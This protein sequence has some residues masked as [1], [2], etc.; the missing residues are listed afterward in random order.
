MSLAVTYRLP[1]YVA[2]VANP[3][4]DPF[5]GYA[6]YKLQ[7]L[8]N[9]PLGIYTVNGVNGFFNGNVHAVSS[10][11]DS[12]TF[13]YRINPGTY[14]AKDP[15]HNY[16]FLD[17][18]NIEFAYRPYERG[19]DVWRGVVNERQYDPLIFDFDAGVEQD[20]AIQN[21]IEIVEPI[22]Y[23]HILAD[24]IFGYAIVRLDQLPGFTAVPETDPSG[25]DIIP[26]SDLDQIVGRYLIVINDDIA[27]DGTNM[28][29]NMYPNVPF[30][31]DISYS[32]L[33]VANPANVTT[34]EHGHPIFSGL[35]AIVRYNSVY[36]ASTGPGYGR[37]YPYR[38]KKT[39]R[40]KP[41]TITLPAGIQY[42]PY[43]FYT[44]SH[45]KLF[46]LYRGLNVP[47]ASSTYLPE[48]TVP[49]NLLRIGNR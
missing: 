21:T 25:L 28:S 3:H 37:V 13:L 39:S 31:T 9:Y 49:A 30:H 19:N 18:N 40:T 27:G 45:D 32:P 48:N 23:S 47:P 24:R 43:R 46:D 38:F 4:Y 29:W 12:V 15:N 33:D 5:G 6:E 10:T 35:Q 8:G 7:D 34:V 44:N 41:A 26:A 2:R 14:P 17:V 22:I 16:G 1:P 36:S 11:N 20:T 42:S